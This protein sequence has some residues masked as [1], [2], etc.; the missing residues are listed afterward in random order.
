MWKKLAKAVFPE[1]TAVLK[2][3]KTKRD[4]GKM[5]NARKVSTAR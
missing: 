3:G 2:M 4:I 1:K 5:W